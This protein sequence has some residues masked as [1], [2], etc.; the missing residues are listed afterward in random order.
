MDNT[1]R[2][3]T[4]CINKPNNCF[5]KWCKVSFGNK[6]IFLH[7]F[8]FHSKSGTEYLNSKKQHS[9]K[10][11]LLGIRMHAIQNDHTVTIS[12]AFCNYEVVVMEAWTSYQYTESSHW[13][14]S[15]KCVLFFHFFFIFLNQ[16]CCYYCFFSKTGKNKIII[17]E[18]SSQDIY[19]FW[20]S[21]YLK[22]LIFC[23]KERK[24]YGTKTLIYKEGGQKFSWL[25]DPQ[26]P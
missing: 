18:Y 24:P 12:R 10:I 2:N 4:L 20:Q 21:R 19:N 26:L 15:S 17:I 7:A 14:S 11:S 3:I 16:F 25:K 23:S 5:H 9:C 6:G 8:W 22:P 13:L 1:W